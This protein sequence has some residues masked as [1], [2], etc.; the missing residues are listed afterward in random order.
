[1]SS[2]R[3]IANALH[4]HE[5]LL[6]QRSVKLTKPAMAEKLRISEK[7]V[8]AAIDFLKVMGYPAAYDEITKRWIYDW[9]QH[10]R[11]AVI[12]DVLLPRLH[13]LPTADLGILLML[14]C[15]REV[16][17]NTPLFA[18]AER[19]LK[20]LGDDRLSIINHQLRDMFSY[21]SRPV[22]I[23]A[24]CFYAVAS[25]V[26]KRRQLTF[27]YQKPEDTQPRMRKVDPHHMT[28][29]EEMWFLMG[30]D[31]DR[32]AIRTFALTRM[33][34]V[35]ETGKTFAPR[36]R[37][38]F[39]DQLEYA[40][41]MVGKGGK[42]APWVVRLRFSRP[43]SVQVKE[44]RWHFSQEAQ[45]LPGGES[46]VTFEVA[47]LSEVESWVLSWGKD[48]TVL[49]PPELVESVRASAQAILARYEDS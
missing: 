43:A 31:H 20:I 7:Q 17:R 26:Y 29:C 36:S 47:S 8:T 4:V 19:F 46:I 39:D 5:L 23:D 35:E 32:N 3:L 16:L 42:V 25:A 44:R 24:N 28:C 27:L 33:K 40:F 45:E 1:M 11:H 6:N 9:T 49:E 21:Q 22:N 18:E 38:D 10:D 48:C 34:D 2:Y 30:W 12:E 15:G 37:R 13:E 41:K 14:Q